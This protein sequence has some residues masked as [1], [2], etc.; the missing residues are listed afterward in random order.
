MKKY[1]GLK[2]LL[3]KDNDSTEEVVI[4][5]EPVAIKQEIMEDEY[6]D[7]PDPE[8]FETEDEIDP[9]MFLQSEVLQV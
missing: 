6:Y 7:L 2:S 5:E 8:Q 1:H 4:K 9:L 3:V